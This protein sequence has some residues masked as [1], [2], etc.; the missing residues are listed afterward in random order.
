MIWS[1]FIYMPGVGAG[2]SDVSNA[3]VLISLMA[4]WWALWQQKRGHPSFA[5]CG[6][7]GWPIRMTGG[8][9]GVRCCCC[10]MATS[11]MDENRW[12]ASLWS[13]CIEAEV[14]TRIFIRSRA[15]LRRA[16]GMTQRAYTQR[17]SFFYGLQ[18]V[19]PAPTTL[20]GKVCTRTRTVLFGCC[21]IRVRMCI[22]I[23]IL[24]PFGT[25]ERG[26]LALR[27]A[28]YKQRSPP[29]AVWLRDGFCFGGP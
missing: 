9:V 12:R 25:F 5:T 27:S 11:V 10:A 4:R 8:V 19:K 29:F 17:G 2:S 18:A 1:M 15:L 28:D 20:S 16:A 6:R 22:F 23:R 21:M 13:V 14:G 26:T 3:C 24:I 7:S